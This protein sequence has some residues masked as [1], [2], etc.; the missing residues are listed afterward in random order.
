MSAY[1]RHRRA[2]ERVGR[3]Q[4][5]ELEARS[6]MSDLNVVAVITAKPGEED[7]VRQALQ[8]LVEPTRAED[9][10]VSYELFDSLADS[11]AFVTIEKWRSQ[12]ALDAHMKS[13]HLAATLAA[14]GGALAVAPAIHP[15]SPVA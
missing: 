2:T 7:T 11:S 9:G 14:A 15:L 1:H 10:C 3:S 12:D 13:P 6:I 8:A 5:C 4:C